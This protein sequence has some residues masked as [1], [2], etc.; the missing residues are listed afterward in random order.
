MNARLPT[1]KHRRLFGVSSFDHD[2]LALFAAELRRRKAAGIF[3]RR[4]E[5]D[6]TRLRALKC[7]RKFRPVFDGHFV[8]P[9]DCNRNYKKPKRRE[10]TGGVHGRMKVRSQASHSLT[11]L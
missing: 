8:S 5:D 1:L 2:G 6:S 11:T 3:P 9:G 7:L 10:K 4:N